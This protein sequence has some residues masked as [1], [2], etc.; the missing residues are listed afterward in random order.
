LHEQETYHLARS[1]HKD[2]VNSD[3]NADLR[4][5]KADDPA[6]DHDVSRVDHLVLSRRI[7]KTCKM[8]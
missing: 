7:R 4:H 1:C 8:A 6:G 5:A 3:E 2:A